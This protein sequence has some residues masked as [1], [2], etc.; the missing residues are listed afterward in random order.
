[1]GAEPEAKGLGEEMEVVPLIPGA[2]VSLLPTGC[3]PKRRRAAFKVASRVPVYSR[4]GSDMV[5]SVDSESVR[6]LELV[7]EAEEVDSEVDVVTGCGTGVELS[8]SAGRGAGW[9]KGCCRG[10]C[11]PHGY[12][13]P[14]GP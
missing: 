11:V 12:Q 5:E 6:E 8:R 7:S 1:M 13:T 3:S 9:T 14:S 2:A 10:N 4:G